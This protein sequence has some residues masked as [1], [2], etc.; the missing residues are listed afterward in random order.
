[1]KKELENA[2]KM[3]DMYQKENKRL[4]QRFET[5]ETENQAHKI[6]DLENK[7]SFQEK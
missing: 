4:K 2:Y 6:T 5:G 3:I 1:M 7:L